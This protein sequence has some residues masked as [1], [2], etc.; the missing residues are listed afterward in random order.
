MY[1]S[2]E[3]VEDRFTIL[4][5]EESYLWE[6]AKAAYDA[7]LLGQGRYYFSGCEA[8][9]ELAPDGQKLFIHDEGEVS[10]YS[11]PDFYPSN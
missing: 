3:E 10:A 8:W 2:I 5:S 1:V 7:S 9:A 6:A 11:L 4:S